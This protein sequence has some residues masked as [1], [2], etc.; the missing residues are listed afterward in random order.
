M[1]NK[2]K[3]ESITMYSDS[4]SDFEE[5]VLEI[6]KIYKDFKDDKFKN[7]SFSYDSEYSSLEITGK[8]EYTKKELRKNQKELLSREINHALFELKKKRPFLAKELKAFEVFI[9][10]LSLSEKIQK[11]EIASPELKKLYS[12]NKKILLSKVNKKNNILKL[13]KEIEKEDKR[14]GYTSLRLKQLKELLKKS[15]VILKKQY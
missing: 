15:Q 3:T 5:F 6:N 9:E 7:I 2:I 14:T 11:S 13:L 4:S 8:R 10:Y 12:K 1:K